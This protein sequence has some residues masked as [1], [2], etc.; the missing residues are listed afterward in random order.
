MSGANAFSLVLDFDALLQGLDPSM[1]P[2][3]LGLVGKAARKEPRKPHLHA[4]KTR[5]LVTQTG[6]QAARKAGN[7]AVANSG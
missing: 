1:I 2:H 5:H 7:Y 6:W 4:Q 3:P